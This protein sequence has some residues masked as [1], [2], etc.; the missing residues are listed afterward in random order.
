MISLPDDRDLF[1]L[2]NRVSLD[3][4]LFLIPS[5]KNTATDSRDTAVPCPYSNAIAHFC[6][7]H[8]V[9]ISVKAEKTK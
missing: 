9:P 5:R 6:P 3:G 7:G 2:I 4:L 8:L 1:L